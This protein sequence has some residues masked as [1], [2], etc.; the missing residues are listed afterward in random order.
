MGNLGRLAIAA[1]LSVAFSVGNATV[2]Y[3]SDAQG[4]VGSYDD[5][6]TN[7]AVVGNVSAS[8]SVS[9]IIGLAWDAANNRLLLL[10][11]NAPAVYAMNPVSGATTLLFNPGIA[12]QGGAVVGT[13]LY[14]IDEGS[15][16]MA[17]FNLTTFANLGLSAPA[18]SLHTHALG[19]NPASGQLYGGGGGSSIYLISAAG[20]QG[21]GVVSP[22]V[23]M[24][25]T[26]YY[27]GD[28]L[29][30]TYTNDLSRVDGSTGVITQFLT[31]AQVTAGGLTGSVSGVAVAG[32]VVPPV[33]KQIPTLSD[34]SMI[35]L[36]VLLG[37]SAAF[38]LSRHRR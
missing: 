22:A 31:P 24:E 36:S 20:A 3:F 33:V 18:L 1:I 35:I 7:V 29:L 16:T 21:A 28:F 15:M 9:Q 4:H 17:A 26:D 11:R 6:T 30:A 8:F 2:V 12:F 23:N 14:G 38:A 25:D 32:L 34:W 19:V 37:L 10:D 27:N 13:T 5:V